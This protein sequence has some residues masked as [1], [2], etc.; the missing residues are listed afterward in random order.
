MLGCTSLSTIGIPANIYRAE[1]VGSNIPPLLKGLSN[2]FICVYAIYFSNHSHDVVV[3][4][5]ILYNY[6]TFS[7]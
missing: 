2:G 1:E 6:Y 7:H 5:I 4:D 3:N